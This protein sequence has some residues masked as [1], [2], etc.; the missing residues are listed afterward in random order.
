[1]F[2]YNHSLMRTCP[3]QRT[4]HPSPS[5][6]PASQ[7]YC[8][9]RLAHPFVHYYHTHSWPS[10]DGAN[11][12]LRKEGLTVVVHAVSDLGIL[13]HHLAINVLSSDLALCARVYVLVHG[14]VPQAVLGDVHLLGE[15]QAAAAVG[16]HALLAQVAAHGGRG[17]HGVVGGHGQGVEVRGLGPLLLR[18]L[19]HQLHGGRVEVVGEEGAVRLAAIAA[20]GGSDPDDVAALLHELL[21]FLEGLHVLAHLLGLGLGVVR[22]HVLLGV[23]AEQVAPHGEGLGHQVGHHAVPRNVHHLLAQARVGGLGEEGN[24]RR[25]RLALVVG[26][27]HHVLLRRDLLLDLGPQVR[28]AQQGAVVVDERAD[29]VV[30]QLEVV[31]GPLANR[32]VVVGELVRHADELPGVRADHLAENGRRLGGRLGRVAVHGDGDLLLVGCEQAREDGLDLGGEHGVH[33]ELDARL[34]P[35]EHVQVEVHHRQL[36]RGGEVHL[37]L[38]RGGLRGRG[39]G[40]RGGGFAGAAPPGGCCGD[41]DGA[42]RVA[43]G[44]HVGALGTRLCERY[45]TRPG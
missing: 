20:A 40:V 6:M 29:V 27:E 7:L 4:V 25:V 39:G 3:H 8:A 11:A 24:E 31:D 42:L 38:L 34:E 23:D 45:S 10:L 5:L 33:Q 1:M 2:S 35:P 14:G 21:H 26:K 15:A 9:V 44:E 13:L 37:G 30:T 32:R 28:V 22:G 17:G 18:K 12:A 41:P 36:E 16:H 43:E 19:L